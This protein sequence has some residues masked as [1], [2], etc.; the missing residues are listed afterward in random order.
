[1]VNFSLIR[2]DC[3]C[4][5]NLVQ[6]KHCSVALDFSHIMLNGCLINQRRFHSLVECAGLPLSSDGLEAFFIIKKDTS[7]SVIKVV[8]PQLPFVVETDASDKAIAGTL[9]QR[10][11]PVAFFS[12]PL[13]T[14][15]LRH[16]IVEKEAYAIMECVR[17]WKHF[18]ARRHSTIITVTDQRAV[19]FMFSSCLK[20]KKRITKL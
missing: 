4:Y 17:K 10:G 19:S 9:L 12:R 1:M 3:D 8:D 11:R 16:H 13:S 2:R 20:G 5:L 15:E 7:R 6:I 18:L 14:S